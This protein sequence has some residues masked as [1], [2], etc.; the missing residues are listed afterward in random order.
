MKLV[1]VVI[2]MLFDEGLQDTTI[3]SGAKVVDYFLRKII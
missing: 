1:K 2:I 3:A